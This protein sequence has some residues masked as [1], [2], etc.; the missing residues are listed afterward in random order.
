MRSLLIAPAHEERLAEA[1]KSAADAIVV[2]LAGAKPSERSGART[3]AERFLKKTC[4]LSRGVARIVRT[5]A[6][7][8]ARPTP[9]STP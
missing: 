1:L 5:N 8:R 4:G 9:I 2:D 6:P 3:A 7:I